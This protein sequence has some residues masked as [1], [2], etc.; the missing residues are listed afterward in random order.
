VIDYHA[1][2]FCLR[3][4]LIDVMDEELRDKLLNRQIVLPAEEWAVR[5]AA[6]RAMEQVIALSGKS[7]GAVDELF[8]LTRANAA[9]KCLNR[10]VSS[11]RWIQCV[12]IAKSCFNPSCGQVFIELRM[13][14]FHQGWIFIKISCG[15]ARFA[16]F[17]LSSG[18]SQNIRRK[19][20]SSATL[21]T[22][23]NPRGYWH[24]M[25]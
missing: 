7:T 16:K 4:G 9:P 1:M 5:Y 19:Y 20:P 3:V 15:T 6:Y 25:W 8:S 12:P 17:G 2:R 24:G 10:N 14:M 18:R 22:G 21:R 13:Q 23:S 11:V